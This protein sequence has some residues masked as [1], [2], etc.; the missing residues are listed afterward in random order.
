MLS[1]KEKEYIKSFDVKEEETSIEGPLSEEQVSF[2]N[3]NEE[4]NEKYGGSGVRTF[5]ESAASS[6]T[7]GLS[8]QAY[9]AL[10]DDFKEALRERRKR[11]QGAALSGEV[12][13]VVAPALFSGGSSLLAKG[14]ATAGKGMATAAK[15]AKAAERLT[16][17]GMKSLIKDTGKKKFAREVLRKSVEKGAGSAV[18][19]TFYGVGELIEENALGNAEFNAENLAAYAGK[20]ALFGG[21]VGGSLGGIGKTVSIV[22]PKIKGNKIV[23][24]GI[25]KIDNFKQNMTNPAY[26]AMKLAGFADDKIEK[27][28][29]EQP[30]MAKN[31]PDVLGK[32]M[33][34]EGLAKSIVSNTSLLKNSRSYLDKVGKKIGKT[35]KA[36]DDEIVD[37]AAFP[38]YAKVAQKQ[39]DDLGLLKK[40]FQR[41]DGSP[42]NQEALGY[43]NKIDDEIDSLFQNNLLN[44]KPYTASQLQDMKIKFHKLGRYD[45]T[46]IPTVKDDINR[47]MGKAVRDELVDFAGRVDSPLGKQLSKELTDYSSLVTFVKE[48]NKKIGGQTNFPKLR[49][50]FFGLSAY[51]Y[52]MAPTSAAGVAALTSAFARSDL[53]NKLMVLTDIEKSNIRVGQKIN[54]SVKKFF[55]GKK[56]DKLPALSATLLTGNPLARKTEGDFVVGKPKDERDAIKNMADNIDKIKDNP[57]YMN[58]LMMDANLQSSAPQTYQQ[59]KQIAGRAFV[60]LDSKLPR[61]TQNVN[62]FIKKSYPTSDQEI[63]KFKKYVQAVQNPMSVLKDLNGGVLSREGIEA[64]RFVYPN[65][66]GEMQSSVYDSLEKS[67]GKTTYKQRLQLGILMDMPTDLALEPQAIQGLQSFY[68]EAQVSQSGGAISAAAAKQMDLSESQATEL[69][70][71]SNRRDLN[72]S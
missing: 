72:R 15:A 47:V 32:V 60:F 56:F 19:G 43:I 34:S 3:E 12:T 11:N 38:T 16:A 21:L 28:I 53:K 49:D 52:G 31:M 58:K 48:F 27:I 50:I 67:G 29:L 68:K 61:Q 62:P 59:L 14:A 36:M 57:Y 45:K 40:K 4:L 22:V 18:E 2:V 9:A 26:N 41:P 35:V 71:V 10:G 69:E 64:V 30:A 65:L 54:S 20:G 39:I 7:F 1:D 13:G 25:E 24:M 5:L 46:G 66:Y 8:D 17:S 44:N 37:K 55:K 42:L 63:Y 33:K 6:I 70:K 51:T 23:G